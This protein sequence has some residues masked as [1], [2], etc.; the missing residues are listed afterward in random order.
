MVNI[1]GFYIDYMQGND[2]HGYL[3]TQ[4]ALVSAGH[5]TVTAESA[6]SKSIVLVR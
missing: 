6:F 3:M 1:L 2:V 4:P 5:G